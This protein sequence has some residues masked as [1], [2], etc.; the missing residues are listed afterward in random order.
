MVSSTN[1]TISAPGGRI[2]ISP[3][4][5]DRNLVRFTPAD[6][7]AVVQRGEFESTFPIAL[8]S[9]MAQ[10]T[11]SG[12][13]FCEFL[14]RH[15][16]Q[17]YVLAKIR[18]QVAAYFDLRAFAG[19]R[20][21]DFG[22]GAGASTFG[23]AGMLPETEV[24]GV[25]LDAGHV[26]QARMIAEYRRLPNVRFEI[27]PGGDSLPVKIGQFDFI[28]L[29]AVWEHLL[30]AERPALTKLLW[31]AL[32]PGGALLVNQTPYRWSPKE[33]HTTGLWALNYLPDSI[34]EPVARRYSRQASSEIAA[35]DWPQLLRRG[36]RGGTEGEI[37]RLI[38]RAGG[39]A[40]IMQ[41]SGSN[42]AAYWLGATGPRLRWLKRIIA[43]CFRLTDAALGTVPSTH[44]DVVFKK[45]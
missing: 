33:H 31:S 45:L 42:R 35:C 44:L 17:D 23:L 4:S 30:P 43:G 14:A 22:C 40:R 34:A 19:K 11:K 15:E 12:P 32:K 5:E 39:E 7:A 6:P 28:M 20:L 3:V 21:L 41:P 36:I 37:L 1:L 10:E 26:A 9:R 38:R 27:S 29:S 18:R 25:E 24:I 13:W 16:M 2:N 8:L